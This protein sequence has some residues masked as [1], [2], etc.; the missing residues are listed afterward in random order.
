MR[1]FKHPL[2]PSVAS[3][4]VHQFLIRKF[5][6]LL[7]LKFPRNDYGF[8]GREAASDDAPAL[9][10]RFSLRSRWNAFLHKPR[11]DRW[12]NPYLLIFIERNFL[13]TAVIELCCTR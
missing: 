6:E 8:R 13:I 3:Q 7:A 12:L 5:T 4:E 10:D 11:C 2:R 9:G 1:L